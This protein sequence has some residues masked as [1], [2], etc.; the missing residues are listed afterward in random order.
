[1]AGCSN[2]PS[3]SQVVKDWQSF[4][5]KNNGAWMKDVEFKKVEVAGQSIN[6]SVAE[7][8]VRI[9][10]D[11]V[12]RSG[13]NGGWSGHTPADGFNPTGG[14]GQTVEWKFLYKKFD[15]GWRLE[16]NKLVR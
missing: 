2:G 8:I 16:E 14:S 15:T 6:G 11:W 10:G 9:T 5:A 7:V 12:G 4:V 13:Y 1:L 3:E